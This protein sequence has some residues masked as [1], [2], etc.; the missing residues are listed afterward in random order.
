MNF[1]SFSEVAIIPSLPEYGDAGIDLQS[2]RDFLIYGGG[3]VPISLDFG[4]EI[5]PTWVGLILGRSSLALRGIFPIGGV[6]DN[7][8]RGELVVILHNSSPI[9]YEVK[10]GDKIAQLVIVKFFSPHLIRETCELSE[11]KR[12]EKGLGSSG[13]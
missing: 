2:P 13:R 11:S 12:G 7:T 6:I 8:Y 9:L 1:K 3:T 10:R 4:V 5:Y